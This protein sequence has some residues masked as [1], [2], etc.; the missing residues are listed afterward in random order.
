MQGHAISFD[1][2]GKADLYID[3]TYEG[4]E[5]WD[6]LSP[7]LGV[8]NQGGFRFIGNAKNMSYRLVVL[9]SS[10]RDAD[11]P[12]YLDINTG[13]FT[14]F[15]DNKTPGNVRAENKKGN[16]LLLQVFTWLHNGHRQVIPPFLIFTKGPE[17]RDIVFRGL[18]APGEPSTSM[19]DD[20]VAVW[21]SRDGNRFQNYRALFTILNEPVVRREW[22]DAC[23]QGNFLGPYCPESWRLWIETGQYNALRAERTIEYRS[24][25][26]QLPASEPEERLI[27]IIHRYFSTNPY[28]FERFAASLVQMMDQNVETIDL[29]RPWVDG[30]RDAVGK[31]RIGLESDPIH[32]EFAMEAK[33]YDLNTA[34]RVKETSRLI[35]RLRFRQ[36]GILVTTSFV[37]HQAYKEIRDDQHPVII[38]S[39]IDIVNILR[40]NGLGNLS[41]LERYL[42]RFPR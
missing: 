31:Y 28:A 34:V 11:W 26:Q 18:A 42:N 1:Q 13:S 41:D 24:K 3:A 32:V 8:G 23:K 22:L 2:L 17:R 25:L 14:Y 10:L 36:F 30:G 37:H 20:L 27:K 9:Y 6:A 19:T 21:K 5:K 4:S 7:L 38:I 12:D 29:T 39:A 15:G 35:S 16:H 33:C 40:R